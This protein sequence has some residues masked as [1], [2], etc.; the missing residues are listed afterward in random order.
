MAEEPETLRELQQEHPIAPRSRTRVPPGEAAEHSRVRNYVR[1]LILGFNDG[2]VSVYA[3]VAGVAGAAFAS[4]EIA[5]AGLAA[6]VAGALSMGIGEY[7][8]T[9]SQTQYYQAE[10]R[11]EREHIRKYPRLERQEVHEMLE[12]KGYPVDLVAPIAEHIVS[13]EDRF[14]EFMMREEFG[15]GEESERSPLIAMGLVM[16]AFAVGALF[17]VAPFLFGL[18]PLL[19]LAWSSALSLTGLFLAGAIKANMSRL[20]PWRSGVEMLLLGAVA[21]AITYAVGTVVGVA[22]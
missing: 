18:A 21:A 17:P 13:D 4:R 2:L 20:S 6:S 12:E 10:E 19:G 8:S 14:V 7:L 9:K 22:A 1:D 5:L 16:L 15:V 11:R 3:I